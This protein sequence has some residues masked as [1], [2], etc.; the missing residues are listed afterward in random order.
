[1]RQCSAPPPLCRQVPE[2]LSSHLYHIA[3][4]NP[5]GLLQRDSIACRREHRNSPMPHLTAG[6]DDN[7]NPISRSGFM[8][9]CRRH[10]DCYSC[11]RHPLTGQVRKVPVSRPRRFTCTHVHSH[12]QCYVACSQFF[13]CQRRHT[14]YDTVRT[15]GGSVFEETGITFLNVSSASASAF[16]VDM[17]EAAITGMTGVCVDLDSSMNEGCGNEV[18]AN[19]K[20]GLIG[21]F[22][23]EFV[24]KFLCGLSLTVR[25]PHTHA[26]FCISYT[27]CAQ[28]TML[29]IGGF[30]YRS[31]ME[32]CPRC[33]PRATC[34]GHACCSM[35]PRTP[36]A[37]ARVA[38]TWSARIQSVCACHLHALPPPRQIAMCQNPLLLVS[39]QIAYKSVDSSSA[40]H[41]MVLEHH[42][43]VLF[44]TNCVPP[45]WPPPSW[46]CARHCL[47][48]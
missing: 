28:D 25:A 42:R 17:E 48:T 36:M 31:S 15:S 45:T 1:M 6:F 27:H 2:K 39:S 19:I 38:C 40:R 41:A 21:C 14:F 10:S 16:D 34:F 43:R 3:H 29:R 35:A 46:T 8:V 11:G 32:I 13:Q 30:V 23:G 18:A 44:A 20:D 26:L 33:R 4:N 5:Q 37:T 24:A 12:V 7:G 47:T 9:P 22:D